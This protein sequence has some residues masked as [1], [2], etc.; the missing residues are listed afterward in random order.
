MITSPDSA[1]QIPIQA[2]EYVRRFGALVPHDV[3]PPL[4]P[5]LIAGLGLVGVPE[6]AGYVVIVLAAYA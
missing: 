4:L 1:A 5:L 2:A 3:C 6:T